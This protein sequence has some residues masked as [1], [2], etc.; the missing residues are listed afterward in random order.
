MDKRRFG[1]SG[2]QS[3]IAI[4][5]A[6]ALGGVS[7]AEADGA[8][9]RVISAGVNHIDVAPSYGQAEE[10][11]GP[12]MARERKRFFLGCKTLERTREGAAAELQRSLKKLK[13][14]TFDLYQLHAVNTLY[15]LDQAM[16]PGGALEAITAAREQKLTHYIGITAHGLEAPVI[17]LEALRRFDFDSV[18]FPLNFVLYA[19]PAYR[20]NAEALLNE[21]GVRDVGTMVIKSNCK[22]PWN[23][24]PRAFDTWYEPF[25]EPDQIQGALNFALSQSI[26][27]LCTSGDIRILPLFLNA[28]EHWMQLSEN[29]Q[30]ELLQSASGYQSL[31]N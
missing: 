4:F 26:T 7:Q 22:G 28:C 9:E 1:R 31:F 18:L 8:M 3:T 20:A 30:M 5:G 16:R 19:N 13:V 24:R 12:W 17:L 6:A 14:D 27:G 23:D 21:C 10:R 29:G 25:A 15:D 2:H 11:L